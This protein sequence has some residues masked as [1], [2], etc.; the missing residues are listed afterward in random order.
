MK[1]NE[2]HGI[3]LC[4]VTMMNK[5][6]NEETRRRVSATEKT[7]DREDRKLLKW[8]GLVERKSGRLLTKKP[9]QPAVKRKEG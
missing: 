3:C 5:K 7:K 9:Y 2:R 4:L 8:F 1:I 6:R